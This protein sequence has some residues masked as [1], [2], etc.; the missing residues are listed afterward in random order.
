MTAEVSRFLRLRNTYF[1]QAYEII[2]ERVSSGEQFFQSVYILCQQEESVMK[3][4]AVARKLLGTTAHSPYMPHLSLI[5]GDTNQGRCGQLS[6]RNRRGT[7]LLLWYLSEY[8]LSQSQ[9]T[10]GLP[11]VVFAQS[12]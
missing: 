7:Q 9:L 12:A 5:Y 2:F 11:K 6:K 4:H 8:I 3:A 1:V 10:S